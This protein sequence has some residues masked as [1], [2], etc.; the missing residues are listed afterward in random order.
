MEIITIANLYLFANIFLTICLI[1]I[2]FY[3]HNRKINHLSNKQ[4]KYVKELGLNAIYMMID[5]YLEKRLDPK[6]FI[7][8]MLRVITVTIQTNSI[9]NK[10]EKYFLTQEK[11][12]EIFYPVILMVM[13][14]V[15]DENDKQL[16]LQG[17]F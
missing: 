5:M 17:V 3:W 15:K 2:A 14:R 12:R 8:R 6:D 13:Y 7:E 9:L 1:G 16:I 11:I 4:F 10:Q